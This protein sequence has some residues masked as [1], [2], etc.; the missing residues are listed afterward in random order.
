MINVPKKGAP[1]IN[2]IS[3]KVPTPEE[4]VVVPAPILKAAT[5][6][7]NQLKGLQVMWAIGGDIGEQMMG[8]NVN[9]DHLEILTTKEGCDQM[10]EDLASYVKIKPADT[11]KKL[12][13]DADIDGK[14]LP[15][16]VKSRYA[17]LSVDGIRVEIYGDEQIKVGEWEWGDPLFFNADY[18]YVSGG[19]IPLVPLA[20]KSELALGLGW[21][22]RVSLISDAVLQ[23]HHEHAAHSPA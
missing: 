18:T 21:L 23:K 2:V 14:M 8:V 6:V 22:D 7:A 5:K 12:D 15:I 10:C 13:R 16:Y 11:E 17:E 9:S 3:S 19:K 4:V 20:L 1:M